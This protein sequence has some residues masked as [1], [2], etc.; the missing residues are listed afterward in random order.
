M[1]D[2]VGNITHIGD[3]AQ[4][5]VYYNNQVVNPSANYT[6]DA[7]YRLILAQLVASTSGSS[8]SLRPPGTIRPVWVNHC[9]RMARP[10]AITRRLIP[11]DA[12]GNILSLVVT[13]GG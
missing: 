13:P 1:Y 11:Y 10:C 12:V 7:I 9:P 2:P 5:T 3:R 8:R 4:Q 6:Y